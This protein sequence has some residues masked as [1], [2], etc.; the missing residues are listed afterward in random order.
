MKNPVCALAVILAVLVMSYLQPGYAQQVLPTPHPPSSPPHAMTLSLEQAK[1]LALANNKQLELGRLNVQEKQ[2]AISAAKTDYLPKLLGSATYLHF[3]NDLGTV[4][5]TR[6]RALGGAQ[7]GPGGFIQVP[8]VT[9]PGRAVT[10]NVVNQDVTVGALMIAQPIT[11][12]IGVSV[13]VDLARAEACIAS[14]QLEK[15]TRDL[16]SGVSQAF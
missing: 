11:K 4:V 6:D 12:L 14:A 1:D 15:G 16:V 3:N 13:L 9:I 5:A 8:T 7:I 10:A 2:I